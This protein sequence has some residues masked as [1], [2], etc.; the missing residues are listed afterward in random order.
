MKPQGRAM[1]W[2]AE[3]SKCRGDKDENN[4]DTLSLFG[5]EP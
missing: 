3:V 2:L 4:F 5:L 1:Q